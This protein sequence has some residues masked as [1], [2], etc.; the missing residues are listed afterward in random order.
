MPIVYVSEQGALVHKNRERLIIRKEG[1]VM[2]AVHFADLEQV[3]LFGNVQVTAP[4]THALLQR[5]IDTVFLSKNGRFRGRLQSFEGRNISLRLSQF[6]RSSEDGFLLDLA[7]RMVRGKIQNCRLVLRRQQQ[8][9]KSSTLEENLTRMHASF[10]RADKVATLDELRGVEGNASALYFSA[11][12]EVVV[13]SELPFNGRNRRPPRDPFNALLSF[14]YALL[15]GTV[16]TCVH[17]VGLDP[18]LGALHAPDNGKPSLVLDLME[19]FRPLLVDSLV[20][21]LVNRGQMRLHD[22]RDDREGGISMQRESLKKMILQYESNL[23]RTVAYAPTGTNLTY[24]EVCLQQAR[25]LARHY[26]GTDNY[27]AFMPR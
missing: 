8:R 14:G 27:E 12:R 20:L 7:A 26:E 10:H 5:G 2:E 17:T 22:F 19:E 16:N 24:R 6:R 25:R 15:L 4:A 1:R 13:N 9:L 18:F 3:V 23:Q 11:M 21:A